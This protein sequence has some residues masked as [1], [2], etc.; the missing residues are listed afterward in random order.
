MKYIQTA[1]LSLV[2]IFVFVTCLSGCSEPVLTVNYY[3]DGTLSNTAPD[4]NFYDFVSLE[5]NNEKAVVAWDT[6]EWRLTTEHLSKDTTVNIYFNYTASPFK[7][8]GTGYATLQDAFNSVTDT[9]PVTIETTADYNGFAATPIG[10]DITLNLNGFTLDGQGF[11]TITCNGTLTINGEGTITNTISGEYSKSLVNYGTLNINNITVENH[12]ANVAIWNSNNG[13]SV[14]NIDNC[15]ISRDEIDC[16]VVI[17]S[18]EMYFN[19]GTITGAGD[20]THPVVY[21]NADIAVLYLNGGVITNT[22]NNH[23]VYCDAGTVIHNDTVAENTYGIEY[24]E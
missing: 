4:R 3:I 10:S 2:L 21:N 17:N 20:K 14:M 8:N 12:T 23:T 19:S 9:T 18:G 16:I 6:N 7:I 15:T 1:L 22:S 11:D 5:C 13:G 24:A